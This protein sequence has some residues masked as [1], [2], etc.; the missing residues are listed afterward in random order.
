MPDFNSLRTVLLCR[1]EPNRVPQFELSV[2]ETIKSRFLGRSAGSLEAEVDFFMD[3]G[4]DFVPVT[5]GMRQATRGET[6]GI[7]GAKPAQTA[8]LKPATAQYNP[9]QT[10]ATTRMWA[11]E[12]RGVIQDEASFESFDWPIPDAFN[13][14]TVERLGRLLP[15]GAKSIVCVGAVFTT[16][17]MLMGMESFCIAVA[18]GS[19][20][21]AR[22]VRRVG[23]TQLRVVENLL[24]FDSVG[25]ICMPDDLAYTSGLIVSPRVLRE[26]VFPWNKQIGDLVH[27]RGLPYLYHSDGRVYDVIDDLIACGFDSLHPCEPASMDIVE[28][29]RKYQGRLCLCGNINLDSTLTLGTPADVEQEVRNRIRELAPGGGYCC[30]SSNSVPEYVPYEN[31]LAMIDA[32]KRYGGY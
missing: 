31:Y 13:Y 25:A 5:I 10:G 30:G 15:D 8:I 26:H 1:G 14:E 24:Q 7:L 4:Y 29:K 16:S 3:A 17:W 28:L 9:F 6:S 11:E 21:V 27:A 32:V 20:L 12:G 22:L 18:E 19:D 2:D 23:E